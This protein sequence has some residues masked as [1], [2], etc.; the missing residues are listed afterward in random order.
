LRLRID[1]PEQYITLVQSGQSVTVTT[2]AYADR[3]FAG[4]V[5]RI[6][7]NVTSA[8]RTLTVEAEVE[9]GQ[10]LLKPGQ[11]ATVRIQLPKPEAAV[12]IPAS[13]VR[14]QEASSHVFVIHDGRAEDRVVQLGQVEGELVE[15]KTGL[16]EGETVATSNLEQLKDGAVVRQ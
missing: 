3:T 1:I 16:R 11:F 13:A 7:P 9:N 4:R 15:V 12:L 2:S 10:G 14:T 8:S 6:S 5:A